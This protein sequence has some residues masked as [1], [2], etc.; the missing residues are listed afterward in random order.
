MSWFRGARLQ[1][2]FGDVISEVDAKRCGTKAP[3]ITDVREALIFFRDAWR[4]AKTKILI[5]CDYG[6]SRSPALAYVCVADQLG[7]GQE[8]VAFEIVMKIRPNA[9]P[10]KLVVEL[11]D[12][13]LARNGGLLQPLRELYSK[14]NEEIS[15]WRRTV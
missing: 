5:Q 15:T 7:A 1:L 2:W 13:E 14:I 11:G 9:V 4:A 10:N 8:S 12:Q 3:T 6:A